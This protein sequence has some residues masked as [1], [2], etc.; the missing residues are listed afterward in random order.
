MKAKVIG[1]ALFCAAATLSAAAVGCSLKEHTHDYTVTTVTPTCTQTGYTLHKCDCGDEYR[2]GETPATG[3]SYTDSTIAPTCTEEGCTLHKCGICGDEYKENVTPATGH[4]EI[5]VKGKPATCTEDGLTDGTKCSVC[6]EAITKQTV[7]KAE[8]HEYENGSCTVCGERD[9]DVK[10][11]P[12]LTYNAIEENGA[13][14]AY[15][16]SGISDQEERNVIIPAEHEGLPVTEIDAKAFKGNEAIKSVIIPDSVTLIGGQ[17]FYNCP[18]LESVSLGAGVKKIETYAFGYCPILT[19]M[20]V[21]AS[22]RT[23]KSDGNCIIEKEGMTV[24][25][26]CT[27]SVIPEGVKAISSYAF[28]YHYVPQALT[29]PASLESVGEYAFYTAF[30]LKNVVIPKTVTALGEGAFW[31]SDV[32]SAEIRCG[33][34]SDYAFYKCTNLKKATL[35]ST[36]TAVGS[37][38]FSDCPNLLYAE[39]GENVT[40]ENYKT[41]AFSNCYRLVEVYNKSELPLVT[42]TEYDGYSMDYALNV[43]T[44]ESAKGE[45]TEKDGYNFYTF[46]KD[47]KNE[48]FLVGYSGNETSLTLPF[49]SAVTFTG[50][51]VTDYAINDYAFFGNDTITSVVVPDGVTQIG[52]QALEISSLT[53]ITIGKDVKSILKYALYGTGITELTVPEGVTYVERDAFKNCTELTTVYWNAAECKTDVDAKTDSIQNQ[54][55]KSRI[56][57]GCDDVTNVSFGNRVKRIPEGLFRSCK[58]LTAVTIPAGVEFIGDCA[59]K[60]CDNVASVTFE[61]SA[62][63]IRS[64]DEEGNGSS[65]NPPEAVPTSELADTTIAAQHLASLGNYRYNGGYYVKKS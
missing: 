33:S 1:A 24:I 36:V 43:C 64:F 60:Y 45:F 18:A 14:V 10:F 40:K 25:D 41:N 54:T 20:S 51:T 6:G 63:W 52:K 9:P 19:A 11:T 32:E 58:K 26:G 23:L 34:V 49:P 56:F 38:A 27:S 28:A 8:G 42:H 46:D 5:A 62:G 7:I 35:A 37:A 31:S 21:T 50:K 61:D 4:T 59:F 15:A 16:V 65:S 17:A 2:D 3:H 55:A 57:Y 48:Y 39:I 44:S 12:T 13:A 30:G 29:F 53:D 47:G 22:N